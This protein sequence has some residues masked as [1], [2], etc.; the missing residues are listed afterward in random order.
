MSFEDP[1]FPSSQPAAPRSGGAGGGEN[2]MDTVQQYWRGLRRRWKLVLAITL[3]AVAAAVVHFLITPPSFEAQCVI[4]IERRSANSLLSSQLPWLDHYFN[5]EFYPTQYRLLESRGLAEEVV[6]DLR[7]AE[8]ERFA[9]RAARNGSSSGADRAVLGRIANRLRSSLSV[10]P[11]RDTQLVRVTYRSDRP[12][13]AARIANAF[14]ESFIEFGIRTRSETMSEASDVLAEEI[15]RLN[16]EVVDIEERLGSFSGDETAFSF[17]PEGEVTF[18]RLEKLNE[19][20]VEAKRRRIE[21]QARYESLRASP[22]E[23]VAADS[24][25]VQQQRAE[26]LRLER[27]YDSKAQF[28]K[29]GW[30]EMQDLAEKIERGQQALREAVQEEA[31][32]LRRA[33]LA[34][35]QGAQREEQAL[36]R[37]IRELRSQMSDENAQAV[38][39]NNLQ[40]ELSSRRE[41]LD[42]LLRRRSETAFATRL[43]TDKNSNV[44][45]VDEALVPSSPTHPSLRKNLSAG[46]AAGLL[47][48]LGAAL[49]LQ[50]LD[51]TLKSAEEV[52]QLLGL[53]V[54]AVIPDVSGEGKGS[55]YGYA[56]EYGYGTS[57]SSRGKGKG[58]ASAARRWLEK[59]PGR[60]R[61]AIELLP[62]TRPRLAVSEAYR[63][64]RTALL[65]STAEELKVVTVTSVESAEGK[66]ATATNLA[67]V[68]AQLGRR[69]VLIDGDLRK[70]RLHKVFKTSNRSG[71]VSYLTSGSEEGLFTRSEVGGL[72]L[73]TSGPIPPNP[74]ELL[75]SERM[76]EMLERLRES[77][78]Y[79]VI[80]TPPTLAVTDST[81]VGAR[82]D[83]V[84]LCLR[85]ATV[86]RGDAVRCHDRLRMAEV[87]VLGVVLNAHSAGAGGDGYRYYRAYMEADEA[88]ADTDAEAGSAA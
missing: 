34:R 58:G 63:S 35:Y 12:D 40:V 46:V 57:E 76:R 69:V 64:L 52:E 45:I 32:K 47:L 65:L 33:A 15:D 2:L 81:I 6:R 78:D 22:A 62:H 19:E 16:Q 84:V 53:P 30:P 10:Q 85:S 25:V 68:L 70:P 38:E 28:Y 41:L 83:G 56:Y 86:E 5:L 73:V 21:E 51:R 26:Q 72:Y 37:E 36:A 23:T 20:L 67:V 87:K 3:L 13:E 27:E 42:D 50:F 54:L 79:V 75:A 88:D 44:R 61:L 31:E 17:T 49:L 59:K 48:G 1:F 77:F 4:Q 43:Q 24:P 14:A 66:T 55:G 29:S 18:Q 71:L 7:L 74:S 60:E 9:G 11:I 82:S 8:E 39:F 80:D